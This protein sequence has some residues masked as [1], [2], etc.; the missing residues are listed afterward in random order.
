M[1]GVNE[2]SKQKAMQVVESVRRA[3]DRIEAALEEGRYRDAA[4]IYADLQAGAETARM[5]ALML[6]IAKAEEN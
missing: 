6:A 1:A 4:M 3:A 5:G 2:E